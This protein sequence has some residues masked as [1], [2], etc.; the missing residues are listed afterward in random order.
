VVSTSV[1]LSVQV[2]DV[3]TSVTVEGESAP[4]TAQHELNPRTIQDIERR[5]HAPGNAYG[6]ALFEAVFRNDTRASIRSML[7]PLMWEQEPR[8]RLR[9]EIDSDTP[10]LHSLC[11]ESLEY[12][13]LHPMSLGCTAKGGFYRQVRRD[14]PARPRAQEVPLK[15]LAAIATPEMS[16]PV[17]SLQPVDFVGHRDALMAP[18]AGQQVTFLDSPVSYARLLERLGEDDLRDCN[19]L[20]LVAPGGQDKQGPFLLLED[21]N[22]RGADRVRP[23]ELETLIGEYA[24]ELGLVVLV[25]DHSASRLP[26]DAGLGFGPQI[27]KRGPAVVAIQD[28]IAPDLAKVFVRDFYEQLI[29]DSGAPLDQAVNYARRQ[30]ESRSG[31][32]LQYRW[33]APLFV[34]FSREDEPLERFSR[35]QAHCLGR[36]D[37]DPGADATPPTYATWLL[38][39]FQSTPG[40]PYRGSAPP[41]A[42]AWD[43]DAG[44]QTSRIRHRIHMIPWIRR[45]EDAA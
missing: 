26:T 39:E 14:L 38:T 42:T 18:L 22:G 10:A 15:V 3:S 40:D 16:P 37:Q 31:R 7:Y 41:S 20:H 5:R 32:G 28:A 1:G 45:R 36:D 29:G 27:L 11:W 35:P 13:D 21:D 6:R 34:L 43:P 8:F 4:V 44:Q 30:L 17:P 23:D 24:S 2:N 9:L 12:R 25:A 19:V 33:A